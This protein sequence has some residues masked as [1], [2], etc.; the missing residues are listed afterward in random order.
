VVIDRLLADR[1]IVVREGAELVVLV[2]EGVGVD[3]AEGDAE[4]FGVAAQRAVVVDL[5]PRDVQRDARGE[6]SQRAATSEDARYA[7]AAASS[8]VS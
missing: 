4:V 8:S 1:R 2:L 3:R 7:C 5:V 6:A